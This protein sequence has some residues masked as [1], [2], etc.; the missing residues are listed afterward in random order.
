MTSLVHVYIVLLGKHSLKIYSYIRHSCSYSNTFAMSVLIYYWSYLVLFR[1]M[2]RPWTQ[3]CI[4]KLHIRQKLAISGR[5]GVL[6][7]VAEKAPAQSVW[8][9]S[10]KMKMTMTWSCD[11]ALQLHTVPRLLCFVLFIFFALY[12][13]LSL[14]Q[15]QTCLAF[16]SNLPT[17][18]YLPVY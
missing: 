2:R 11:S 7:E 9:M 12:S 8:R 4:A 18:S 13:E 15:Q 14:I 3:A 1:N 5:A 17:D 10:L 6:S 16:A